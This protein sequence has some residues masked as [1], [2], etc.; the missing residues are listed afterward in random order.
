MTSDRAHFPTGAT[1]AT[2]APLVLL[3]VAVV[4]GGVAGKST[5]YLDPT[6]GWGH[7]SFYPPEP[8]GSGH[9]R[10]SR[11]RALI[12]FR[13]IDRSRGIR[14]ELDVRG[15]RP[16][17]TPPPRLVVETDGSE[18]W[19]R[20]MEGGWQTVRIGSG[21]EKRSHLD[22]LLD[23][24]PFQP[25]ETAGGSSDRRVLGLQLHTVRLEAPS[26]P[27]L[28]MGLAVGVAGVSWFLL[29]LA[30]VM[31][32]V[33]FPWSIAGVTAALWAGLAMA[34]PYVLDALPV[35][36]VP[37]LRVCL[38]SLLLGPVLLSR[39][40]TVGKHKLPRWAVM[41]TLA[42]SILVVYAPALQSGFFWDDFDFARPIT[43]SE[44][45]FTF[46][47]TWNWTG[48][49]ND[50]YRPL[51]V[52]LFQIDYLI[53]GLRPA[54][55][56]MTNILLHI[57]NSYLVACFLS[58]WLRRKWALAGATFFALHPMAATG[59]AWISERT[60]VLCTTFYCLALLAV[61]H[62][63]RQRTGGGLVRIGL[64]YAAAL[65]SKEVAITFPAVALGYAACRR[66]LNRDSWR[67]MWVLVGVGA[68]Y[69]AGWLMLF[70]EKLGAV[71]MITNASEVSLDQ[72][73]RSLLRLF[74]LAL[75]PTYYP[76]YDFDFLAT[77]SAAY[78]Y[79]GSTL[80]L[81]V[82]II[83]FRWGRK[84][85]KTLFLFATIWLVVTVLPLFNIRYADYIRLGYLP[86]VGCGMAAASIFSF[87]ARLRGPVA[88]RWLATALLLIS[89]ARMMPVDQLI[90]ADWA[91]FGRIALMINRNKEASLE[92]QKRIG[93]E[94]LAIF[95][96][97]LERSREEK[98]HV[99]RLL[100]RPPEAGP[101]ETLRA[102]ER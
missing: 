56:H 34:R 61:A 47:G 97:Q 27:A 37:A 77:E 29:G 80:F 79:A 63:L 94:R 5:I 98:Q 30:G 96:A 60:D 101:S 73:W 46:Y 42:G 74:S 21:P 70:H 99:E 93:P 50:Y 76:S 69:A 7:E 16:A 53:Y 38:L 40:V 45:L 3:V 72:L 33:R 17:N 95:R 65:A 49:G 14:L 78:L 83:L 86:A 1:V 87:A 67:M 48:I 84:R 82:G 89:I 9:F 18:I 92:W 25:A 100:S 36:S 32:H 2:V 68:I 52:T 57:V 31:T 59:I 13:G 58:T 12:H 41:L 39:R 28:W 10:W 102:P 8:D 19:S 6:D 75:I 64:S 66:R 43:L 90:V 35:W 85:E 26:R 15:W 81:L 22:L 20:P 71:N 91:H 23:V 4:A 62:Y 88:G 51:I 24:E 54:G 11:P 55:F 44:W